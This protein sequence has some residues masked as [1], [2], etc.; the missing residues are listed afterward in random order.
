M[1]GSMRRTRLVGWLRVRSERRGFFLPRVYHHHIGRPHEE[2]IPMR[3][4]WAFADT[5]YL[6]TTDRLFPF[7]QSLDPFFFPETR[8]TQPP[9]VLPPSS[10][11][12]CRVVSCR[13]AGKKMRKKNPL[14]KAGI[15]RPPTQVGWALY[16]NILLL[17]IRPCS[18]LFL[19]TAI[20]WLHRDFPPT[21]TSSS[22]SSTTS[23]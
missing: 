15:Y 8:H 6:C 13:T 18:V 17:L 5:R 21:N 19:L 4:V 11:V 20:D 1:T 22:S 14:Q 23:S 7:F 12:S 10:S 3:M 9:F 16:E 2:L